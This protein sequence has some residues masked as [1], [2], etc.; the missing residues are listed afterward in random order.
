MIS[1]FTPSK[2]WVINLY[3]MKIKKSYSFALK[4]AGQ[5]A[6][7]MLVLGLI[8]RSYFDIN[9][10]VLFVVM[11]VFVM[12]VVSFFLLQYF[13]ERIIYR[14]IKKIYR[15]VAP[16]DAEDSKKTFK[17]ADIESLSDEVN[18]FASEKLLE[19]ETLNE[20][21]KY[22]REFMG[23][24]AHELK[25][26]LFSIQGYL[27]TLL[28]GAIS[29]KKVRDKYLKQASKNAD[30]LIN[31]VEDLDYISKL[32]AKIITLNKKEFDIVFLVR[33]VFEMMEINAQKNNVKLI[34]DKTYFPIKV[35][36]D[37]K[38]IEQVMEN[39]ITNAIKY[40][41]KNGICVVRFD[42]TDAKKVKVTVKDEGEGI[43][44]EHL[45]RIFERFYRV[46]SSRSREEG[47]SGLGLSIVKHILEAHKETITV[48][49]EKG[50][51]TEF[52]FTLEKGSM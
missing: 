41:S 22:R 6:V 42:L 45:P 24:V 36:A 5:L 4:I 52:C 20:Q 47:G 26:P 39:L 44:P 33:S 28:D 7:I 29:D 12:F 30:R 23:N 37:R 32:D 16:L 48:S 2:A 21:A 9:V 11:F 40:G 8:S 3:R 18:K 50:K 38:R 15:D 34:F 10:S 35:W 1:I 31:I 19:I 49:S 25:T 51:G 17:T 27:L 43:N 14:N 13:I 46:D